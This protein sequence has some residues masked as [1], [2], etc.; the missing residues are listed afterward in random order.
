MASG[1][2]LTE[3]QEEPFARRMAELPFE[4]IDSGTMPAMASQ[5]LLTEPL[6][7][8]RGPS[9][10]DYVV[11]SGG[12]SEYIDNRET[13]SYGELGIYFARHIREHLDANFG[14]E[15]LREAAEGI[16]ATVIGA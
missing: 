8:Y 13:T 4:V 12:V 10:V 7:D 16:R 9:D 2:V 15:M 11:C 6:Q 3:N 14:K 1:Q 5:L